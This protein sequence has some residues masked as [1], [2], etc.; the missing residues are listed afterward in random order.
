M[1]LH[2]AMMEAMAITRDLERRNQ[3]TSICGEDCMPLVRGEYVVRRMARDRW[4]GMMSMLAMG[5][6]YMT[7][8]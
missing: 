7:R 6:R 1:L 3:T 5:Q 2:Q 4:H 8:R